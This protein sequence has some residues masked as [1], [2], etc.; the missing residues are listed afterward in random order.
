VLAFEAPK[1]LTAVLV[2][3]ASAA[4]NEIKAEGLSLQLCLKCQEALQRSRRAYQSDAVVKVP[5]SCDRMNRI[6]MF[7]E[8][9]PTKIDV[10][11]AGL[12]AV[13]LF[14]GNP[15]SKM[16]IHETTVIKGVCKVY[17]NN[18]KSSE[19]VWRVCFGFT[20][21]CKYSDLISVLVLKE[22]ICDLMAGMFRYLSIFLNVYLCI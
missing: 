19:I 1:L 6:V 8:N 15:D 12:D 7:M 10:L 4:I 5:R 14:C 16:T 17:R 20:S 3:G 13:I 18:P 11:S 9:Y 21:L 22:K 2:I